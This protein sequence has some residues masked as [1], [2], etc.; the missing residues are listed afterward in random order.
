MREQQRFQ[1]NARTPAA[2]LAR[3]SDKCEAREAVC[4]RASSRPSRSSAAQ[5]LRQPNWIQSE[6][7]VDAFC[8]SNRWISRIVPLSHNGIGVI[9][10]ALHALSRCLRANGVFEDPALS[11]C[12]E[13]SS[14][15]CCSQAGAW[16]GLY[17]CLS[18]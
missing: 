2:S 7:H 17:S 16:A 1:G 6:N 8:S 5:G 14:P 4:S 3:Q 18:D 11:T 12:G 10:T 13:A 9:V 15:A